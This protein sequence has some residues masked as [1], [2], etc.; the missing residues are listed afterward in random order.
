MWLIY[1]VS[2]CFGALVVIYLTYKF[3]AAKTINYLFPSRLPPNTPTCPKKLSFPE[4]KILP[5]IQNR[6][7]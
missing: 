7:K 3:I 6:V 4:R 5:T 1:G 2:G